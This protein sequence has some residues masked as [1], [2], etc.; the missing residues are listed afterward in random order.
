MCLCLAG[1]GGEGSYVGNIQYLCLETVTALYCPRLTAH[2]SYRLDS[3][4]DSNW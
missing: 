3:I 1:G 4:G 2:I